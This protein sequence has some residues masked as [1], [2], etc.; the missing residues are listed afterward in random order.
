MLSLLLL[1]VGEKTDRQIT[2]KSMAS[3]DIIV[4]QSENQT[5]HN[6]K[7]THTNAHTHTHTYIHTRT[8]IYTHTYIHTRTHIYTHTLTNTH[9]HAQYTR[10][11]DVTYLGIFNI[12][13]LQ[14]FKFIF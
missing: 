9:T 11:S 13:R 4:W 7:Y 3:R 6:I 14:Y 2:I 12:P 8:H 10:V 1:V 5:T